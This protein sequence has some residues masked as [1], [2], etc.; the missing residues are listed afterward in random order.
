MGDP[1]EWRHGWQFFLQE[2][3]HLHN[4]T[5]ARRAH[6][7]SHSRYNAAPEF[8]IPAHLFRTL[9]LGK[10]HLPLQVTERRCE[11]CHAELDSFG[12]HHASCIRSGRVKKRGTPPERVVARIFRE[13]GA[14]VRQNVFSKDMNVQ[15]AADDQR[16][17]EV[18]AQDLPCFGGM[19]L[20]VDVILRGVER[21]RGSPS[22][23]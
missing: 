15:V 20:A 19:Q 16:R 21:R 1:G 18:L 10:M 2:R 6:L 17:V 5:A 12:H 3:C 23:R 14:I 4:Q 22:E 13:A 7:R 9:L 11:G 8:T